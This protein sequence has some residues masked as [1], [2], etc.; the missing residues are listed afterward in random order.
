MSRLVTRGLVARTL[1]VGTLL[2]VLI[3]GVG[4]RLAMAAIVATH[5]AR[6]SFSLGGT[7]TV[8]GLGAVSGL[9]GGVLALVSRVVMR[10]LIPGREWPQYVV[11]GALLLLV[12]LR[13]L[14]GTESLGGWF[15]IPLVGVY[16]ISLARLMSRHS[17]SGADA[18]PQR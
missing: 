18:A 14:H 8:I 5:G 13:G 15:F 7:F 17:G 10:F 3:L 16:G 9:S 12:T 11:L 2:G 6:P 4:G 1:V